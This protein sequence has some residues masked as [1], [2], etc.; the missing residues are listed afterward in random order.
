MS[1]SA[2]GADATTTG[3]DVDQNN[4]GSTDSNDDYQIATI[5]YDKGKLL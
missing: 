1:Q 2:S 5:D 3:D 4:D